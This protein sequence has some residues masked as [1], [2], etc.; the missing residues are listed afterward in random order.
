MDLREL[1][2]AL[3]RVEA[4]IDGYISAHREVAVPLATRGFSR[5]GLYFSHS[6]L[7]TTQ[8]AY[9]PKVITPPL[10][11]LGVSGFNDF[12]HGSYWGITYK[13]FFF[14]DSSLRDSE[15]DHFHEAVHIVQWRELGAKK[16]LFLYAK[17]LK[18]DGY[19]NCVLEV[20]AYQNQT[21]FDKGTPI[22]NFEMELAQVVRHEAERAGLG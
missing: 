22:P 19:W 4:W 1:E 5:L 18:E 21:K 20:M 16:F 14:I 2:S 11:Q 13:D 10:E 6:T 8:V 15:S 3:P 9:V 17:G 12:E 7:Q